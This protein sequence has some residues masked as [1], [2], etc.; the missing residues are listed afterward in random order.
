M[1]W[2]RLGVFFLAG[3]A[4]AALLAGGCAKV[5]VD[6]GADD[7]DGDGYRRG[8]HVEPPPPSPRG[9]GRT[10][11][12]VFDNR[13]DEDYDVEIW[14]GGRYKDLDEV[15]EEDK[16]RHNIWL[17]LDELPTTVRYKVGPYRGEFVVTRDTPARE[18]IEIGR[19]KRDD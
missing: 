5:T 8:R 7:W 12:L 11:E 13:S 10:V 17:F 1:I 16:L 19:R 6:T 9:P 18:I 4:A 2:R 14:V 3:G 15:E